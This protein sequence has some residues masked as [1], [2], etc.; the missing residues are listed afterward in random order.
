MLCVI[1]FLLHGGHQYLMAFFSFYF[2]MSFKKEKNYTFDDAYFSHA[3][4]LE[5]LR[6]NIV[7]HA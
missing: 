6:L 4:L 3:L 5:S 2:L 7:M 1:Y